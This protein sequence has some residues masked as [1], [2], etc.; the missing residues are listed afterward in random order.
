MVSYKASVKMIF[1]LFGAS[2]RSPG[3][4]E[5]WRDTHEGRKYEIQ[6]LLVSSIDEILKTRCPM[7][8]QATYVRDCRLFSVL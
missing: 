8:D 6:N 7:L 1:E 3:L 4:Q 2:T 5:L